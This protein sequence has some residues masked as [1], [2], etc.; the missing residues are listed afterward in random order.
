MT[1][2]Y[3]TEVACKKYCS[4]F[5]GFFYKLA[6]LELVRLSFNPFFLL[7]STSAFES[8]AFVIHC[9]FEEYLRTR[10]KISRDKKRLKKSE[11]NET[12]KGSQSWRIFFY[13]YGWKVGENCCEN[14]WTSHQNSFLMNVFMRR[15][16]AKKREMKVG[17]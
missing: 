8:H 15:A 4:R 9:H 16:T 11:V 3:K 6:L 1:H 12:K 17:E 10:Q 13:F 14:N 7:P 2:I 5:M